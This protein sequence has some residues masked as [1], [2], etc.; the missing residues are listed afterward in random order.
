[1]KCELTQ[2]NRLS[3]KEIFNTHF[4]LKSE[5]GPFLFKI[6]ILC[7]ELKFYF[8]SA[9]QTVMLLRV[10]ILMLGHH[11]SDGLL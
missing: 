10:K 1:M 9:N 5:L 2:L 6:N 7:P 8:I 11:P 4:P 3:Y